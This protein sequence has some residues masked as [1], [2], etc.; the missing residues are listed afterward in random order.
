M[1]SVFHQCCF[2]Y[3]ASAVFCISP[4][5]CSV[6][7]QYCVLYLT[8]AVF[9]IS[10]VLCSVYHQ[11]CVLYHTSAVFCISPVL[12]WVELSNISS[13]LGNPSSTWTSTNPGPTPSTRPWLKQGLGMM[14]I[15]GLHN[16]RTGV[17]HQPMA[18]GSV[19]EVVFISSLIGL[20]STCTIKYKLKTI[21]YMR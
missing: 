13:T 2:L 8:S 21:N 4:V 9:C 14:S 18:I 7:H 11:C 20:V 6:S 5:L 19:V 1:C 10:P 16:Y 15:F 17:A 3:P 12:C